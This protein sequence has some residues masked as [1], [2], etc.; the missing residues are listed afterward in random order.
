MGR[1]RFTPALVAHG[2]AGAAGPPD[3]RPERRRALIDALHGGVEILRGGGSALD[4]AVATVVALEN[5]PLFN[6]G[7]GSLLTTD[8]TIE[9]D[10]SVMYSSAG[11]SD[12]SAP[13]GA[14]GAVSRVR[15]PISLARAI[16]ERTPHLLMVG[17]GAERL[18]RHAGIRL[19]NSDELI[20]ARA[21]ERW[22]A[23][24]Q[25]RLAATLPPTRGHGTVGAV[26]VDSRGG[27]AAATS[28]GG[29]PGKLAGRVGDSAIIGAGTYASALGAASATGQGEAII[30]VM[31][32]RTV[33]ETLAAASPDSAARR[34]IASHIARA[35]AE[36][37]VVVVD[38][39]GRVG[40]AH[41][42]ASMQVA[43]FDSIRGLRHQWLAPAAKTSRR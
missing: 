4:A 16:M 7:L 19:C 18:A 1:A 8:G 22:L 2:G 34:V 9:M 33:V 11:A 6:A 25:A 23:R 12:G 41:N 14:V 24:R 32:C 15:N 38:H 20:T 36:A 28:T 43:A 27:I 35:G 42:A 30:R 10:A 3:E 40:Y 13:A 39:R 5:H 21:R 31:L 26:A 29:V 17:A 37:G